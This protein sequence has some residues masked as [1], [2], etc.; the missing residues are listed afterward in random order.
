MKLSNLR[1][2]GIYL[3]RQFFQKEFLH[4]NIKNI[5][6]EITDRCNAACPMCARNIYGGPANP[7][8]SN[9]EITIEH[10]KNTFSVD[11]I[12]QLRR[13]YFCG[14]YGDPI[15]G[16]DLIK[17]MEYVREINP[18]IKLGMNSNAGAGSPERW[19]RLGEILSQKNDY[20]CF[21]IDGLEDTNHIYRR[22]VK[23]DHVMQSAEAFISAKGK[24]RWEFIVFKHNEHQ[25]EEAR[26]LSVQM[27]F[28]QFSEKNSG[29]FFSVQ[30]G[31]QVNAH[32]VYSSNLEFEYSIEPAT[33]DK[34]KYASKGLSKI[35]SELNSL[36]PKK[37]EVDFNQPLLAGL[38][39]SYFTDSNA[40]NRFTTD[41][42]INCKAMEEDSIFLSAD[43]HV[44]PCCWTA[45]PMNSFW[46]SNES[47][48]L[49]ELINECGG[50]D[51]ISIHKTPILKIIEGPFFKRLAESW[52]KPCAK[53]GKNI[54]CSIHCGTHLESHKRV[55]PKTSARG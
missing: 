5:H 39:N 15:L 20:C 10:F 18:E 14:N 19:K 50:K 4:H 52:N 35:N 2:F 54:S 46:N 24:A 40:E 12:K 7:H 8:L 37:M 41:A 25:I 6:V 17:I 28:S 3:R 44:Y 31:V 38:E 55:T 49:R 29:R 27:G 30:N 53:E 42:N 32:P 11:F 16:K 1:D 51:T 43:G 21:S 23:W 45:Y 34:E 33:N 48:Q 26:A 36:F 22:H 9:K 13:I 47:R